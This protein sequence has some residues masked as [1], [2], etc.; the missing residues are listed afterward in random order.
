MSQAFTLPFYGNN[1]TLIGSAIHNENEMT[2]SSRIVL[3]ALD[4]GINPILSNANIDRPGIIKIGA[5]S[6]ILEK[7]V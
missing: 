4:L 7:D 6:T 1:E 2:P 3:G 5:E